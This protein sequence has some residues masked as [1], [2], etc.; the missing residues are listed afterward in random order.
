MITSKPK[1]SPPSLTWAN[2]ILNWCD[3][4]VI[5]VVFLLIA[6]TPFIFL[7]ISSELFEFNKIIFVYIMTILMTGATLT[8]M[9]IQKKWIIKRT[10]LDFPMIVFVTA[11]VLTTVFSIDPYTSFWGYYSRF[12]GGLA[13]VLAY[14]T[15]FY[16]SASSLKKRHLL[17][18]ITTMV[19][20]LFLAS[21]Y[22]FP[23]HFGFSPSCF[24][25]QQDFSVS[26]WRQDVQNRVFGT[27]GQPN[28]LAA[29]I[30]MLMPL[31]LAFNFL[32]SKVPVRFFGTATFILSY[33]TLLFTKSRS[34]FLGFLA[35]ML[36][37]LAGIILIFYKQRKLSWL[38]IRK[39]N[40]FFWVGSSLFLLISI[41]L[42]VGTPYSSS[43]KQ[44]WQAHQ[45]HTVQKT[46]PPA[47]HTDPDGNQYQ[48]EGTDSG[49][50]RT[51][52]WQGA[53]NIWRRYP[54]LGS[55]P[56]TFAY[57][58]YLDRPASHNNVSE[59]D[60]LYNKAHNEFLNYLANTGIIGFSAYIFLLSWFSISA[61]I[62]IFKLLNQKQ[63]S[64]TESKRR[65][66]KVVLLICI[67]AGFSAINVSNFFGFS[68]VTVMVTMY[69]F[70][71]ILQLLMKDNPSSA[72]NN[73][74]QTL[75]NDFGSAPEITA[76]RTIKIWQK[77]AIFVLFF[78]TALMLFGTAKRWLADYYYSQGL[79]ATR[80]S[81]LQKS[82]A[83][84]FSAIRLQ[85]R[86]AV[87]Y[88]GLANSYSKLA[89][90]VAQQEIEKLEP[91]ADQSWYD[92]LSPTSQDLIKISVSASDTSLLLNPAHLNFYKTRIRIMLLFSDLSQTFIEE[93]ERTTLL[94][95]KL[96][97]TDPSLYLN[98][99]DA[100]LLQN[101]LDLAIESAEKSVSLKPDYE[102]ARMTLANLFTQAEKYE[103]ALEQYQYVIDNLSPQN[104]VALLEIQKI[105]DSQAKK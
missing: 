90:I 55:G 65:V 86:E 54:L 98:L 47:D 59:W 39:K 34:G 85:P 61:L 96:A 14:T 77:I 91:L 88:D 44:F 48:S 38:N 101:Q 26:C 5:S 69:L 8:K 80:H 58:Y 1:V 7:V 99:S 53:F 22:A 33:T 49:K 92:Q 41:S 97:P 78:F 73:T 29:Y 63:S 71:A 3:H 40:N 93:A 95:I 104:K 87:F 74:R 76:K 4:M 84:F 35:S 82:S 72:P 52:V 16:I 70:F 27:F 81:N 103:K 18:L 36:M 68:T 13:S 2:K 17:P 43:L 9:I 21:L 79:Q 62:H 75:K 94:A 60:F 37:I 46:T 32:S 100:K 105:I 24:A 45:P 23:E 30:I 67:V 89:Y 56:E 28:W 19:V 10:Y 31:S 102:L 64:I 12:N 50:I 25:I 66:R 51:I 15:L 11:S 57:S 20:S 83:Y 6:V 42:L